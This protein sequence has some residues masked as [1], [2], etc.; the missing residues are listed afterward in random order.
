MLG[1]S[2]GDHDRGRPFTIEPSWFTRG[3]V[4]VGKSGTGK[5][6]DIA[7]I[8]RQLGELGSSVVILDWTGEHAETL[9]ELSDAHILRP[10]KEFRLALLARE[11]ADMDDDEAVIAAIDTL[12]HYVRVSFEEDRFTPSQR[13]ILKDVLGSLYRQPG[14]QGL[15]PTVSE[16]LSKV[17]EYEGAQK[18]TYQGLLESCASLIARLSPLTVGKT[19]AVFDSQEGVEPA[20]MLRPGVWIVDLSVLRY[21]QA[22]NLVSQ[23]ILKR[24]FHVVRGLGITDE[25]RQLIIVDEAHNIAPDMPRYVSIP[26]KIAMENRKYG[27]GILAATTSPAQLSKNLLRNVSVR[28]SH[29]LDDGDDIDLMLRFMVNKCEADRFVSEFM[30]LEI[31][32]A[33]VRVSTPVHIGP[34]KVKITEP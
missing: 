6:H 16:L 31:G 23:L 5:S 9:S 22:K 25:L 4:I 30:L 1:R 12:S 8:S 29:M 7:L 19:G 21:D 14:G 28:L 3:G 27:Q 10:G 15:A 32:E 33:M 17:Q 34:E 20:D 2:I 18:R 13:N 24:L 11:E 26:D